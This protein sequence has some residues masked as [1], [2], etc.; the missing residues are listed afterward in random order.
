MNGLLNNPYLTL[1][2][3]LLSGN[4]GVTKGAAFSNAM[5]GGLLG[6]REARRAQELQSI[7]QQRALQQ[8]AVMQSMAAQ[9]A[10]QEREAKQR[11]AMGVPSEQWGPPD[12][13]GGMWNQPGTG[14][15][16][17]AP[18]EQQ[19]ALLDMARYSADPLSSTV[20]LIGKSGEE[21]TGTNAYKQMMELVAQGL[22]PQQAQGIAYN[23]IKPFTD[24]STGNIL[25]YDERGG[26]S[27]GALSLGTRQQERLDK[28]IQDLSAD[29]ISR[30]IPLLTQI[31][32]ELDSQIDSVRAQYPTGASD[33]DI[34][35]PGMGLTGGF[36]D[37]LV[38][39]AGQNI[40][41]T[42]QKLMNIEIKDRA[43]SAVSNHEMDRVKKE[44]AQGNIK[45]DR[46]FLKAYQ[47]YKKGL[48]LLKRSIA[49]GYPEEAVSAYEKRS[50]LDFGGGKL[51]FNPATGKVEKQ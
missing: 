10:R 33:E 41:Q 4:Q 23:T 38:S 36:P 7:Q 31:T 15:Y 27:T 32:N 12:P 11:A 51:I 43:G 47:D 14:M 50:G 6:L 16:S 20:G 9:R 37:F 21:S 28:N 19:K 40:R 45:T 35:L 18:A 5:G 30:N 17:D 46:Q 29:T 39:K 2:M 49:S 1:G 34:N 22:P 42:F 25:L 3:G 8:Q 26:M 24:Q 13:S 48:D 44:W